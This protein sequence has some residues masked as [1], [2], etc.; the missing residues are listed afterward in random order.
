MNFFYYKIY[1]LT[2]KC[3]I[4]LNL[5]E[6]LPQNEDIEADMTLVVDFCELEITNNVLIKKKD[7]TYQIFLGEYANYIIYSNRNRIE[8]Y[9]VNYEAF[10]STV[11]NIPFSV[12]FLIRNEVILHC[13]SILYENNIVCFAGEKG[14]GKSTLIKALD[15]GV[16]HQYSDDTLRITDNWRAYRAHNLIKYTTETIKNFS[17]NNLTENKNINNKIYAYMGSRMESVFIL[18][19]FILKRGKSRDFLITKY[20]SSANAAL[21]VKNIVGS[22]YFSSDLMKLA[23][24]WAKKSCINL[25]KLTTP[26]SLKDLIYNV[27]F[28]FLKLLTVLKNEFETN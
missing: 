14:V 19:V 23:I 16:F 11:F 5:F 28:L 12:Y 22:Q 2:V 15:G 6:N 17:C 9:A 21:L 25:Y 26:D 18:C 8:C 10:F 24:N 1:G 20:N 4:V 3:N 7:D 13:S 27:E